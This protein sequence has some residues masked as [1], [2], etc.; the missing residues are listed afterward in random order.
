MLVHFFSLDQLATSAS[1]FW[2]DYEYVPISRG[3]KINGVSGAGSHG[4][5][6]GSGAYMVLIFVFC[7]GVVHTT[8]VL[9][10]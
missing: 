7:C 10:Q 1:W 3:P 9:I 6:S 5:W 4:C 2:N 8:L